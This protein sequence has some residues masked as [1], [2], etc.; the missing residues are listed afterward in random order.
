[1][2]FTRFPP[3]VNAGIPSLDQDGTTASMVPLIASVTYE[4]A[5]SL[6]GVPA[7][8]RATTPTSKRYGPSLIGGIARRLAA[9]G[10]GVI[11]GDRMHLRIGSVAAGRRLGDEAFHPLNYFFRVIL[12]FDDCFPI[13]FVNIDFS[14]GT[15]PEAVPY[16]LWQHDP[17]LGIYRNHIPTICEREICVLPPWKPTSQRLVRVLAIAYLPMSRYTGGC[18][19]VIGPLRPSPRAPPVLQATPGEAA[20]EHGSVTPSP[21]MPGEE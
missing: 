18:M 16:L 4:S 14:P 2:E 19:Q 17:A 9:D 5:V 21:A 8:A 7:W 11:L 20:V 10:L 6:T 1:M 15:D 13:F 3:G 12:G